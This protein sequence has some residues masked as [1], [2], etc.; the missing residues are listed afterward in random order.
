MEFQFG[1]LDIWANYP[2]ISVLLVSHIA[3]PQIQ[4]ENNETQTADSNDIDRGFGGINQNEIFAAFCV[5]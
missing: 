2:N 4:R 3:S 1:C 5:V